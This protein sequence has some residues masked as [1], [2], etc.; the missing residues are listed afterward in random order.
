M[1][2][3]KHCLPLPMTSS[4][5]GQEISIGHRAYKEVIFQA[6]KATIE[7]LKLQDHST[8]T[9]YLTIQL[10]STCSAIRLE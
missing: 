7:H 4:V 10:K 6:L 1:K 9:F 3:S 2:E 8:Q 5:K